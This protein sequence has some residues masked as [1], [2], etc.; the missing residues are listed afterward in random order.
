MGP[1]RSPP[2]E[3]PPPAQP[4][5]PDGPPR[6]TPPISRPLSPPPP[7]RRTTS[8][9]RRGTAGRIRAVR[10]PRQPRD[11]TDAARRPCR[12]AP[13]GA[14]AR[15][16]PKE[17]PATRTS[18]P[19]SPVP[20]DGARQDAGGRGDARGGAHGVGRGGQQALG[21]QARVLR[22]RVPARDG[23]ADAEAADHHQPRH[24]RA[25]DGRRGGLPRL[26][27]GLP[28]GRRA[29]GA[30]RRRPRQSL[31]PPRREGGA[32]GQVPPGGRALGELGD[33]GL[34]GRERDPR[35]GARPRA[36]R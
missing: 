31:L 24:L 23:P 2:D 26:P 10:E 36:G 33:R 19:C 4:D 22:G 21:G 20:L 11:R 18:R 1:Q 35:G 25:R 17:P 27:R 7:D 30:P 8:D 12:G 29:A 14:R 15:R 28:G 3:V 9:G 34:P 32:H 6:P 5:G 13:P 16:P